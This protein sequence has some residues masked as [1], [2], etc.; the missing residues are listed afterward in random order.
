ME[1]PIEA[2]V[3][4][5]G[6][7]TDVSHIPHSDQVDTHIKPEDIQVD[8]GE[9]VYPEKN[10]RVLGTTHRKPKSKLT[11]FM[12]K[13]GKLFR[14]IPKTIKTT[15]T[16]LDFDTTIFEGTCLRNVILTDTDIA[17]LKT[18]FDSYMNDFSE[19][20][21]KDIWYCALRKFMIRRDNEFLEKYQNISIQYLLSSLT[22][23]HQFIENTLIPKL[24]RLLSKSDNELKHINSLIRIPSDIQ[25]FIYT[26]NRT[27][28]TEGPGAEFL[29]KRGG[30]NRTK[31]CKKYRRSKKCRK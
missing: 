15:H 8:F 9:I 3:Y 12:R 24:T 18:F 4:N 20:L 21:I 28:Y 2:T 26:M 31:R 14:I 16:D 25:D 19:F 10:A 6:I 30:K 1:E 22:K 29:G 7:R 5:N 17:V 13:L 11:R 27:L 23:S